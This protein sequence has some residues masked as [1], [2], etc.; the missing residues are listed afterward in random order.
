MTVRKLTADGRTRW[1]IDIT[2]RSPD[3]HRA[4]YRRSAN[5]Q[6]RTAAYAEHSRLLA[7]LADTGTLAVLSDPPPSPETTFDE[8]TQSWWLLSAP[9]LKP[10]TRHG[11]EQRLSAVLLPRFGARSLSSLCW[12]DLKALDASQIAA[13][14]SV[15]TRAGFQITLRAVLRSAVNAGMIEDMPRLPPL[16]R[17]GRKVDIPMAASDVDA[18]LAACAPAARLALSLIA[19]AGLRPCE[20]R[21]LRWSDVDLTSAALTVRRGITHGIAVEP[22]SGHARVVP[23]PLRLLAALTSAPKQG[24]WSPVAPTSRGRVWAQQGLCQAFSRALERARP[25]QPWTPHSLRHYYVS[26]LFRL[27]AGAEA[28]RRLV[29]HADLNTT[30]RYA[31]LSSEDLVSAVARLNGQGMGEASRRDCSPVVPLKVQS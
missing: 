15:T 31:D 27:G 2:Y 25:G 20:V 11:Y 12:A 29:G 19:F 3:G 7:R 6:T 8:A 24:P 26:T 30:Q 13:G 18:I 16:P 17:Q 22:K 5:V 21:G 4:R 14:H 1:M 23:V 28:I 10:S 9:S